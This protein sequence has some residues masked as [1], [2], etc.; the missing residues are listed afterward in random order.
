MINIKLTLI[1]VYRVYIIE[2]SEAKVIIAANE[3][4]FSKVNAYVGKVGKVASCLCLDTD[5]EYLYS[6]QRW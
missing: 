3:K 5:H 2:D 6:Y 1:F 4:I